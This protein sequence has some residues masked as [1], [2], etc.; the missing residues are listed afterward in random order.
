MPIPNRYV[1]V[2]CIATPVRGTAPTH[3]RRS[4][5]H[6][7]NRTRPPGHEPGGLLT[8]LPSYP[9]G[10]CSSTIDRSPRPVLFGSWA[11]AG[12]APPTTRLT[13]ACI[14]ALPSRLC[15][16]PGPGRS[17]DQ[18]AARFTSARSLLGLSNTW[19]V[20]L[21]GCLRWPGWRPHRPLASLVCLR[22]ASPLL[23]CSRRGVVCLLGLPGLAVGV[24]AVSAAWR[25]RRGVS[26]RISSP[27][28]RRRPS[29]PAP[30]RPLH[31]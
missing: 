28:G 20:G 19:T 5:G 3:H 30:R 15:L 13:I 22:A 4:Q 1:A 2:T 6:G 10:V 23:R 11:S 8:W 12:A 9:T 25:G 7:G 16:S 24:A 26:A 14:G 27:S 18:R 31:R 29:P 21:G 17:P